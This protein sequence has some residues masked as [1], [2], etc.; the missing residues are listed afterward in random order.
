MPSFVPT[1]PCPDSLLTTI[2]AWQSYVGRRE[3]SIGVEETVS[4]TDTTPCFNFLRNDVNPASRGT[5]GRV[6]A[7]DLRTN[8]ARL[9]NEQFGREVR[10]ALSLVAFGHLQISH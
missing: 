3:T 5:R 6:D 7:I 2:R 8:D 4:R 10:A 9:E 1:G